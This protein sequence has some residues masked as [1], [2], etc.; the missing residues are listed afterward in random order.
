MVGDRVPQEPSA[1]PVLV[2]GKDTLFFWVFYVFLLESLLFAFGFPR[3]ETLEGGV[4]FS[5]VGLPQES[6]RPRSSSKAKTP[7]PS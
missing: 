2:D 3:P 7:S 5:G 6:S 1:D 4:E